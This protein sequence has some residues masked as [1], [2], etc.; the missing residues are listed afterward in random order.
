VIGALGPWT[1]RRCALTTALATAS[2]GVAVWLGLAGLPAQAY[3]ASSASVTA[4]INVAPPPVRSLTVSTEAINYMVC[5]EADETYSG[6]E[7]TLPHGKCEGRN[8]PG[9]EFYFTITNGG[10]SSDI[11]VAGQDAAP[12][13]N[14]DPWTLCGA[15]PMGSQACGGT[16]SVQLPVSVTSPPAVNQYIEETVHPESSAG[17]ALSDFPQ[18]DLAFSV[19]NCEASANQSE[20]ESLIIEGPESSTDTSSTF[21]TAITWTAVAP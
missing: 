16:G 4:T 6:S 13:D 20:A 5:Y 2:A 12:S 19:G 11:D 7:L 17:V 3:A 10:V 1:D 8:E 14:G 21:T 9:G 15:S 18:C